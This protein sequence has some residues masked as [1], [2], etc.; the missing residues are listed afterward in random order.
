M[1]IVYSE[2]NIGNTNVIA[3]FK[4]QPT[5][6]NIVSVSFSK[7]IYLKKLD[8]VKPVRVFLKLAKSVHPDKL[9]D[10]YLF[11]CDKLVYNNFYVIKYSNIELF[12]VW[13][14]PSLCFY[15]KDFLN[16]FKENKID[17]PIEIEKTFLNRKK[18]TKNDV[19]AFVDKFCID[20][21]KHT[22]NSILSGMTIYE[23]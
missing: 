18:I 2:K 5:F 13:E 8:V 7:N 19:C 15:S 14:N 21:E 20:D 16:V 10:L 6:D 11:F 22:N 3:S 17:N 23:R 12:D 1:A 9:C 4:N